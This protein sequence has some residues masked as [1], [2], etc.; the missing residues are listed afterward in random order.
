MS[1]NKPFN[2]NEYIK[3]YNKEKYKNIALRVKPNVF[4]TIEQYAENMNLSKT[5]LIVKCVMYC[6]DNYIDVTKE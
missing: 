6:Y 2:Q 3:A 5:E 1:E 4:D